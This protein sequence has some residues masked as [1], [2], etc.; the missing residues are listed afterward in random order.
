MR[1][2]QAQTHAPV[3]LSI[4]VFILMRFRR[5]GLIRYVCVFVLIHFEVRFQI[6]EFSVK[7]L[8]VLLCVFKRK[9]ISVDGA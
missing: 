8:S 4:I 6:D 5:S 2:P 1:M 3:I 7:T 9:R